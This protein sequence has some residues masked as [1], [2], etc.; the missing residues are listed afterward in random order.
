MP[1]AAPQMRK[2]LAKSAF[3]L[4][5]KRGI[6]NVTLDEV[7]AHI[8]VTK[9]SLYW[10]Y[11]SKKEVILAACDYYY[12][13]WQERTQAAIAVDDDPYGQFERVLRFTVR[14]CLF[15]N[16]N[17]VF[18]SEVLAL[19]LQ[20]R[21]ILAAR[22][23]FFDTVRNLFTRL[24]KAVC[25]SGQLQIADPR[26]AAEWVMASIDGIKQR[27]TFDP[28]ICTPAHCE[29]V[30]EG[31]LRIVSVASGVPSGGAPSSPARQ[32]RRQNCG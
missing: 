13:Q 16:T 24:L 3:Q 19:S 1:V 30:V 17:R 11:K 7:A 14:S 26:S 15:D 25:D 29:V 8:G 23:Q 6:K 12:G 2:K 18:T 9:G 21:D 28:D 10:H 22:S 32:P 5:A 31:L 27:A 4:F 20:D